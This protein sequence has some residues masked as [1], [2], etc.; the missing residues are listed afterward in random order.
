[1]LRSRKRALIDTAWQS[2]VWASPPAGQAGDALEPQD[3][4]DVYRRDRRHRPLA[5]ECSYAPNQ[6][7]QL[8]ELAVRIST[9]S[10]DEI[11]DRLY[12]LRPEEFTQARNQAERELRKAGER[13]Q[14]D[15]VKALRKPTAAAGAVNRLVREQRPKVDEFLAAAATLR[16]AQFAGKGN[17]SSAAAAQRDALEK[18]VSLGGE[19]VRATLQAAA[20][21]DN[22]ARDLLAAQL[23]REPEPAGFGTLLAHSEPEAAKASAAARAAP[24]KRGTPARARPDDSAARA[25]LQEAKKTLG[26]AEAEE[27]QARRRWTQTERDLEK[28]QAAVEKAQRE[29]DRL[30]N[31]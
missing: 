14:A 11:T 28:A 3:S 16:D 10:V 21:D 29:L 1:M 23:V 12:A 30:H 24:G 13:E 4:S 9:V 20:V 31:R 27:R 26:A 15:Q 17:I 7:P 19:P 25:Q 18:L 6:R 2:G 8:L 22:T 5:G